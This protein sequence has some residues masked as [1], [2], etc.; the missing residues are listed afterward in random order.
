MIGAFARRALTEISPRLLWNFTL[1]CGVANMRAISLHQKRL[2]RGEVFPPFLFFSVISSCQLRCQG[3]WVDVA[4][5]R[6]MITR[7][8]MRRSIEEAKRYGCRFFGI[9]GGEPLLHP[10]LLAIYGDHR[11]CYFQMFTN[12]QLLTDDVAREL[13]R[14]GNV[15]P[16]IS[17]EGSQVVSDERRGGNEV[18]D[19]SLRA[20]ESCR[21]QKLITGVA[22]SVCRTNLDLVGDEWLR[23]LISMGV[24]YAWYYTYRPVG[25]RPH[26]DLALSPAELLEVRRFI[27][28]ARKRHPIAIVDAY[29]DD[30]GRALCPMAVGMSHH[31]GPGGDIE[32]CPV[33]QFAA[34]T[35]RD[36]RGLGRTMTESAF[37]KD[38]R[39]V[40]AKTTRGCILLERPD[41]VRDVAQR[42]GAHDSTQ[43]QTAFAELD[44]LEPR[45]SQHLPGQEIPEEH[46]AYR[47]AKKHWFFGFG[48]YQ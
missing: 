44:A 8:E 38:L 45:T 41:I 6:K 12:G 43:R 10:E 22:T 29:W 32:P 31:V 37:L 24:H 39:E 33:I 17:I 13:R 35:I 5:P 42:H 3:C 23:R 21:R 9:L 7:E 34:E 25:P 48:A 47:F 18:L 11:D 30:E 20:V 40:S 14:L 4:S 36:E 26:P 27:V 19:K 2:K 15:T 16:L 1:N 28:Q 46:W